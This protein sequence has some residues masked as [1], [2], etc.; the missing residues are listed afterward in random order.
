MSTLE[1]VPDP[2][3]SPIASEHG[4][5]SFETQYEDNMV[6]EPATGAVAAS[7][8]GVGEASTGVVATPPE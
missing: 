2:P 3:P 4:E 7:S 6:A 5:V 8:T 1:G